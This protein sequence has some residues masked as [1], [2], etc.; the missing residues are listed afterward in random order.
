MSYYLN[1]LVV[2]Y[3]PEIIKWALAQCLAKPPQA[4]QVVAAIEP[5]ENLREEALRGLREL[6]KTPT[7]FRPKELQ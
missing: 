2:R 4:P 3:R 7:S 6:A 1:A 5:N